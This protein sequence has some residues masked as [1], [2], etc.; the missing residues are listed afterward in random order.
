MG[1]RRYKPTSHS[2][3]RVPVGIGFAIDA[4]LAVE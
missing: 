2:S 3:A 1:N 4:T